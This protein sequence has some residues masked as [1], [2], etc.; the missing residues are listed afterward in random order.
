MGSTKPLATYPR[1]CPY[2]CPHLSALAFACIKTGV[3]RHRQANT[4]TA[5]LSLSL[6]LAWG[7]VDVVFQGP[8][9]Y[10]IVL[11][12]SLVLFPI[13]KKNQNWKVF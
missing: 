13:N 6:I 4:M 7:T 9:S 2:Y 12:E 1:Y 10:V 8:A 5:I 3:I 11:K